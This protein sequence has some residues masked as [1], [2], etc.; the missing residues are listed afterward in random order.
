MIFMNP[1]R[2]FAALFRPKRGAITAVGMKERERLIAG[3]YGAANVYE[4]KIFHSRRKGLRQFV[5]MSRDPSV[6]ARGGIVI[7]DR[8]G[9]EIGGLSFV[10]RILPSGIKEMRLSNAA[11]KEECQRE[12]FNRQMVAEAIS[13]ARRRGADRLFG[14]IEET[15]EKSLGAY[16]KAGFIPV[17]RYRMEHVPGKPW[18]IEMVYD[19]GEGKRAARKAA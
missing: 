17:G 13:I 4:R 11:V 7:T 16:K 1:F 2:R 18:A 12:G 6:M 15:N 19:L 10:E 3:K 8:K 14:A 5:E 9:K